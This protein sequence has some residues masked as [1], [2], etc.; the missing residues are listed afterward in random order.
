[1]DFYRKIDRKL[2]IEPSKILIITTIVN[3]GNIFWVDVKPQNEMKMKYFIEWDI[4][5][6]MNDSKVQL[7]DSISL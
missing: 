3:N 1:M 2:D 5:Q 6:R 7:N 4:Q